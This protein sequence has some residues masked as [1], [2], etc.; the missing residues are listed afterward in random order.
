MDN[1]DLSYNKLVQYIYFPNDYSKPIPIRNTFRSCDNLTRIYGCIKIVN[2]NY[3][4]SDLPLFSVHGTL[5]DNWKNYSK[6]KSKTINE[7]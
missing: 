3:T 2:T 4:F 5:S 1:L 7:T 6:T